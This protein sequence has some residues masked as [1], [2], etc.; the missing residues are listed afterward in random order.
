MS[1]PTVARLWRVRTI[2]RLLAETTIKSSP[3]VLFEWFKKIKFVAFGDAEVGG[4]VKLDLNKMQTVPIKEIFPV[5]QLPFIVKVNAIL[6]LK[7]GGSQNNVVEVQNLHDV[8]DLHDVHPPTVAR[9]CG[10]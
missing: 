2:K 4:S 7:K 9:L 10:E 8:Q 5:V 1:S 3:V 6:A